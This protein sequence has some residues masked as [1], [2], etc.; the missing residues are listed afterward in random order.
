[1]QPQIETKKSSLKSEV[2]SQG[3]VT[4]LQGHYLNNKYYDNLLESNAQSRTFPQQIF[5][6]SC[7]LTEV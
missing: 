3:E 1:M 5:I 2:A 4:P 7:N 6:N